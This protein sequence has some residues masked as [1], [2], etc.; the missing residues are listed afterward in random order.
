VRLT[1]D[2]LRDGKH[3]QRTKSMTALQDWLS[4][5]PV[6]QSAIREMVCRPFRAVLGTPDVVEECEELKLL[7]PGI[8]RC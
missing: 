5:R 4:Y 8:E 7:T 2:V 3:E 1:D 6:D